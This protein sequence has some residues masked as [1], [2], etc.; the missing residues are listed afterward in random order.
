M[1]ECRM[2]GDD[3]AWSRFVHTSLIFALCPMSSPL[4]GALPAAGA[5]LRVTQRRADLLA[6]ATHV[7]LSVG[8]AWERHLT[9]RLVEVEV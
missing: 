2:P 6:V 1:S 9:W 7:V 8:G 3:G 4:L 5:L